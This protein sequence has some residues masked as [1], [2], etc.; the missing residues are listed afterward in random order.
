MKLPNDKPVIRGSLKPMASIYNYCLFCSK[1]II[2]ATYLCA[3]CSVNSA[4]IKKSPRKATYSHA[5]FAFWKTALCIFIKW[6]H[7][8]FHSH[9]FILYYSQNSFT[10]LNLPYLI[11]KKQKKHNGQ[12]TINKFKETNDQVQYAG[13]SM[14]KS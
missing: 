9:C 8:P 14:R 5:Y 3:L 12:N 4:V 13:V 1:K 11:K 7:Y 10:Q 2:R 6:S